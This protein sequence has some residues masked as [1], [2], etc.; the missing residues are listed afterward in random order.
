MTSHPVS[1]DL[2]LLVEDAFGAV[3]KLSDEEG[4]VGLT[5]DQISRLTRPEDNVVE[6]PAQNRTRGR[7]DLSGSAGTRHCAE[8][9]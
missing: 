5:A 4:V 6:A 3:G 7:S 1:N 9:S 8:R 2:G